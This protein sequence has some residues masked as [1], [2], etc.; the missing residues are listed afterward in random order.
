MVPDRGSKAQTATASDPIDSAK[1]RSLPVLCR[2]N[3]P[4]GQK[5]ARQ[6]FRGRADRELGCK[7]GSEADRSVCGKPAVQTS[8]SSSQLAEKNCTLY[9]EIEKSIV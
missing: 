5:A 8:F 1:D 2:P 3:G 9:N 6:L 4:F 7:I